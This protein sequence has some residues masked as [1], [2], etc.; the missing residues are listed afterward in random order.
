MLWALYLVFSKL[1][2]HLRWIFFCLNRGLSFFFC[3]L[4]YIS[5]LRSVFSDHSFYKSLY[6]STNFSLYSSVW[7][8]G[9]YFRENFLMYLD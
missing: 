5:N 9:M 1:N 7:K 8:T 3:Y 2:I 6:F 4:C